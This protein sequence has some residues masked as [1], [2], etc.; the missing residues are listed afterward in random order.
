MKMKLAKL[1]TIG[2]LGLALTG[3]VFTGCSKKVEIDTSAQGQKIS[4]YSNSKALISAE[5]LKK[6]KD[7]NNKNLV[8]IGVLDSA[9]ALLPGNLA[10]K[11]IDGSYT[12]WRPDYSGTGSKEA[13]NEEVS[14]FRLSK[15]KMEELLSKAGATDKSTIVVYAADAHHD[16]ARL[17]WQIK[18]L[19]HKDIR[20]LDGGANAWAAANY[21][22]GNAKKLADEAKKTEYKAASYEAAKYDKSAKDVV[23]ALKNPNEWVVIDTRSKDEYDGKKTGSSKDAYGT[24]RIK[25]T[26]HIEWTQAVNKEETTFKSLEELKSIYGNTIKDKKVIVFCQSGVRSAFSHFVLKELLGAKEVYNYDGSWIEWSYAASE[27]SNGKVPKELKDSV[28][29]LTELWSDNKGMIK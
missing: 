22:T 17:Y 24:G 27:A 2:I 15:E 7:E 18:L 19:G 13:L 9:K 6:M 23:D 20:I 14:G 12:V 11:P 16:A 3:T 21:P 10:G 1:F 28:L 29:S 5:Q 26:V 8:V 25:N 4:Q